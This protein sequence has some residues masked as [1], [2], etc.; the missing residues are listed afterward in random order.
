MGIKTHVGQCSYNEW[1]E[2]QVE[3][4]HCYLTAGHD[5]DHKLTTPET[6]E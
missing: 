6:D 4:L 2:G 5:G 3:Y 1:D